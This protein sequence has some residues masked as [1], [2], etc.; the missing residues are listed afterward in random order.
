MKTLIL[1]AVVFT[2]TF[3]V[4]VPM[5]GQA[6]AADCEGR[7]VDAHYHNGTDADTCTNTTAVKKLITVGIHN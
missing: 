2:A 7:M 4:T 5:L 3:V 6:D 1:L